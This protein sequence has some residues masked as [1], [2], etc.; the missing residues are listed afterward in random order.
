MSID[1]RSSELDPLIGC[2]DESHV[3]HH[4]R[5]S[6]ANEYISVSKIVFELKILC[7]LNSVVSFEMLAIGSDT[8]TSPWLLANRLQLSS[9]FLNPL[10]S[11]GSPYRPSPMCSSACRLVTRS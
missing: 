5:S 4:L 3:H 11:I 1:R 10:G 2:L 9:P 6:L 8:R 7:A